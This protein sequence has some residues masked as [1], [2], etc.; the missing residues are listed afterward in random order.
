M[1]QGKAQKICEERAA[2]GGGSER[3]HDERPA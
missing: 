1:G 2:A 3:I